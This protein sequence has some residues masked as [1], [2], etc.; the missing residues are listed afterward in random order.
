LI[1]KY[2]L[3]ELKG[4]DKRKRPRINEIERVSI[5]NKNIISNKDDVKVINKI[6]QIIP[7][8]I[9]RIVKDNQ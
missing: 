5:I 3:D 1:K 7:Q 4:E 9:Q 6:K 2:Y 8:L